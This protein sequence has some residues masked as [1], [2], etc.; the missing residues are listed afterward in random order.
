MNPVPLLNRAAGLAARMMADRSRLTQEH[1]L[2]AVAVR[3]DGAIVRGTNKASRVPTPA[4][5]DAV[6]VQETHAEARVCRKLDAGA[7]VFVARVN[8]RG[9]AM[10]RPCRACMSL[11]RRRR[12]EQVYFT[13]G[14]GEY[15]VV[16]FAIDVERSRSLA[17]QKA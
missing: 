17:R 2:A 4:G 1:C 16:D 15:G 11:L 13:R 6:R 12:V 7:I 10:A 5:G 14:P 8:E 9:W 3:S